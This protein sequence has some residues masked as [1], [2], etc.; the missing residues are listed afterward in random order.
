MILVD[1][2]MLARRCLAKMDEFC[3]TSNGVPTGLEFGFMRTLE[4]IQKKLEDDDIVIC[5][6]SV[7]NWRKEVCPQY[8]AE[9]PQLESR[10]YSRLE[11][12][13]RFL[14][15]LY[16]TAERPGLE[17][18]DVMY[19]LAQERASVDKHVYIYTNDKD[20]LQAVTDC[21]TIVKSFKSQLYMWTPE[22]VFEKYGV[23]PHLFYLYLAFIGDAVDGI[24]GV[25]R[26]NKNLLGQIITWCDE[27]GYVSDAQAK[28]QTLQDFILHEVYTGDFNQTVKDALYEFFFDGKVLKNIELIKLSRQPDIIIQPPH[29]DDKYVQRCLEEWEIY[30]LQICRRY[31]G[32]ILT[33]EEF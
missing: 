21:I 27:H 3:S 12:Y 30:S 22:K 18:D 29:G 28:H 33:N 13:K 1:G 31:A 14:Q 16:T 15:Q 2:M 20:L 6:D 7:S 10:V 23:R 4:S 24:P 5:W 11:A 19:T 8:K 26:I 25:P 9:R 17:A 32:E